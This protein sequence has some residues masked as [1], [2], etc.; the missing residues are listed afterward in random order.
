MTAQFTT[1]PQF[2]DPKAAAAAAKAYAK[3]Q[4]PLYKKKRVLIPAAIVVIAIAA[5]AGGGGGTDTNT[6]PASA[7]AAAPAA[8]APAAQA[9]AAKAPAA[10]NAEAN[11][12]A[13]KNVTLDS[14]KV[15]TQFG[16]A[17]VGYTIN[18]PTSKSSMYMLDIKVIDS[19]GAA[20]GT[21]NGIEDNVLPGRPS[22]GEAMGSVSDSAV[23]PFKC[24]IGDITRMSSQ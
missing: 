19:T 1:P 13:A 16:M 9:P 7:E 6:E 20:V 4:R 8:K 18:N 12:D 11:D 5:A 21:A 15:D 24:E 10:I 23:A 3:A 14:C 22:K 17:T 2:D